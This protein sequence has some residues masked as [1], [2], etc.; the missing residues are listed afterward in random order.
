MSFSGSVV[1][2]TWSQ[3]SLESKRLTGLLRSMRSHQFE[4]SSNEMSPL[5]FSSSSRTSCSSF[6]ELIGSPSRSSPASTS[7]WVRTPSPSWSKVP[8]ATRSDAGVS[9][10]SV[11][12]SCPIALRM[13]SSASCVRI[14][15]TA[16]TA[17][18]L[19]IIVAAFAAAA[20]TVVAARTFSRGMICSSQSAGSDAAAP[21]GMSTI[22]SG[23]TNSTNWCRYES[24]RSSHPANASGAAS[25]QGIALDE[26]KACGNSPWRLLRSASHLLVMRLFMPVL[27]TRWPSL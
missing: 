23:S 5:L 17:A 18:P 24:R 21:V 20:P 25:G 14:S 16:P 22:R 10:W 15:A 13:W 19:T 26:E 1:S 4:N 27:R 12:T 7:A 11:S 2:S 6:S 3:S 9:A 8:N